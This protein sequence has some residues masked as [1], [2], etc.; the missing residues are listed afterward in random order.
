MMTAMPY[1]TPPPTPVRLL[2]VGGGGHALVVA[3]AALEAGHILAGFLDDDPAAAVANAHPGIPRLGG[4]NDTPE[5]GP[6]A[7]ILAIGDLPRRRAMIG[8]AS[9]IPAHS[10][11]HPD[12]SVSPSARIGA[13]V[14]IG[15]HAVIHT[16]ARIG[17]HAI[18][19][20]G[21][22]V[23]HECDIGENVHLAPGAALGGRVRVGPDTLV[24]LGAR[25]IPNISIGRGCTIGAGAAVTRDIPDHT[26]VVGV[27]AR[28]L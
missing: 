11:I 18:I 14:F 5:S 22:I 15:P 13:G 25:V 17:P 24:G 2:L 7:R 3:E 16:L 21:A 10:V 19:N 4:L 6:T 12:A 9:P 1:S 26:T 8:Q 20:S 27:P 23:D 28:P